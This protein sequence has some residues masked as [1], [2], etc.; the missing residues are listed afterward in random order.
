M[1]FHTDCDNQ[2]LILC[3][4]NSSY[5]FYIDILWNDISV[6]IVMHDNNSEVSSSFQA[7][8]LFDFLLI[9]DLGVRN[10]VPGLSDHN[11]C[12]CKGSASIF[13]KIYVSLF[14]FHHSLSGSC[15][16]ESCGKGF[17]FQRKY[18]RAHHRNRTDMVCEQLRQTFLHST[19]LR[20]CQYLHT[21][22][23][24]FR[25]HNNTVVYLTCKTSQLCSLGW[26]A[27]SFRIRFNLKEENTKLCRYSAKE[28]AFVCKSL[29]RNWNMLSVYS[30]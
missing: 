29:V 13:S 5:V 24:N 3:I 6:T 15:Y 21:V 25:E 28:K 2:P 19:N 16:H 1:L 10:S 4:T 11:S 27:V 17:I 22:T 12:I 9:T 20:Q 23:V 30:L 26:V 18:R 8:H 14:K 7:C